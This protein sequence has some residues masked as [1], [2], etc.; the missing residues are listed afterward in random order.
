MKIT[1]NDDVIKALNKRYP[2]LSPHQALRKMLKLPV[3]ERKRRRDMV[4][5]RSRRARY[6]LWRAIKIWVGIEH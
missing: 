2:K 1:V 4:G 5:S 3:I 6:Y